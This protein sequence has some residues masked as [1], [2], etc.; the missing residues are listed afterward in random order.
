M[1]KVFLFIALNLFVLCYITDNS[2]A[3]YVLNPISPSELQMDAYKGT[4][5]GTDAYTVTITAITAT[6]YY[7]GQKVWLKFT[8]ANTGASTLSIN[9]I[10]AKGITL[11]GSA[12]AGGEIISGVYV[13]FVYDETSTKWQ[14]QKP[15][16]TG[17]VGVTALNTIGSTPNANGATLTGTTLNLEPANASF[18]GVV[19]TASQTFAGAKTFAAITITKGT[20]TQITSITT[21]VTVNAAAGII[22]TVSTTINFNANATFTVTNSSIAATS[23]VNLTILNYS[24]TLGIPTCRISNITSTTYDIVITN[25]SQGDPLNGILKIG[26]V[27]N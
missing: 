5:A 21:G 14:I 23:V 19:T 25:V 10:T 2:F 26:F 24:G 7:D 18:G 22:T 16:I 8:N 9:G 11:N 15:H 20:V 12:L 4:C 27:I 3:Q 1:K 13:G 17:G 6:S